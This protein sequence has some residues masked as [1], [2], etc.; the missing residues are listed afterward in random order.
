MPMAGAQ[1]LW[2]AVAQQCLSIIQQ[3]D[4]AF[5]S[6]SDLATE[7]GVLPHV[8]RSAIERILAELAS[9]DL[10]QKHGFKNRYGASQGLW[11]MEDD[12][13]LFA[14]FPLSSQ[15]IDLRCGKQILGTV[16]R[17]NLMKIKPGTRVRFA[18]RV[19]EVK[20]LDPAYVEVAASTGKGSAIELSYGGTADAGLDSFHSQALLDSIF[21]VEEASACMTKSTWA[22]VEPVIARI[23]S[24]ISKECLPFERTAQ[25]FRYF[26]FSGTLVNKVISRW[27]GDATRAES[28]LTIT[29]TKPLDWS[30]LP[31]DPAA[32]LSEAE[33]VFSPSSRQTVF[34]QRLPVEMQR[35]EWLQEW[36]QDRSIVA[37]LERLRHTP[38]REVSAGSFDVIFQAKS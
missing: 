10:L 5:T 19:W 31:A 25:G 18:S 32:L 8:E 13:M 9:A 26:T 21:E 11:E 16:P 23:R 14:N 33:E 6:I 35:E 12:K 24:Q 7:L 30:R 28:D 15:T 34:Q 20:Y 36:Q 2:G 37:A 22:L 29:S 38:L 3:E 4:G 1:K 17:H 27:F